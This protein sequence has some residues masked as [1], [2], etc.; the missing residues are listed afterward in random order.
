MGC[1]HAI[2]LAAQVF[3]TITDASAV[4]NALLEQRSAKTL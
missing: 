2:E 3:F 4:T 1:I